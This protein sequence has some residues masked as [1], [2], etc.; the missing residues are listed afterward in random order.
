MSAKYHTTYIHRA[1]TA[2]NMIR[3]ARALIARTYL[4]RKLR[5]LIASV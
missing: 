1:S 5:L 4:L 2:M 3:L